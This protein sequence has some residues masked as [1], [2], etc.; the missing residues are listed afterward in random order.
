MFH[1]KTFLIELCCIL[2]KLGGFD[3]IYLYNAASSKIQCARYQK[4]SVS[5]F[6]LPL[7][8]N[9]L[10]RLQEGRKETEAK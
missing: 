6:S 9:M 7:W 3:Q 2:K 5:L 4:Y 1:V 8:S 10:L